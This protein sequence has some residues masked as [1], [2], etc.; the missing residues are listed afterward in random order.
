MRTALLNV[1]G[2]DEPIS[3]TNCT[4]EVVPRGA[5]GT[6]DDK[7]LGVGNSSKPFHDEPVNVVLSG[8]VTM[9]SAFP[10][11]FVSLDIVRALDIVVVP[12]LV[13]MV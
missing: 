2:V 11:P 9:T 13:I 5:G 6:M 3:I 10:S 1:S 4:L 7:L 8:I 12:P